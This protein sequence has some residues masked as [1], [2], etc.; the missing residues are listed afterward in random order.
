MPGTTP[1]RTTRRAPSHAAAL[2]LLAGVLLAA[3][4][5]VPGRLG[6][7]QEAE[8]PAGVRGFFGQA[9]QADIEIDRDALRADGVWP[10]REEAP[11]PART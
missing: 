1:R 9:S 2:P 5:G 11:V 6:A 4:P 7:A 10:L 3:L 8:A